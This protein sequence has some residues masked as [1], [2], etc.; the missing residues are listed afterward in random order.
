MRGAVPSLP[1]T[2][3][4]TQQVRHLLVIQDQESRRSISLEAATYSIGR[5]P[6]NSIVLHS[7]RVSRQHAILLRF[8]DPETDNYFFRIVDGNLQGKRSFNGITVNGKACFSHILKHQ[9]LVVF[10][11][12]VKARYHI[13]SNLSNTGFSRYSQAAQ[14]ASLPARSTDTLPFQ[15]IAPSSTELKNL[16]EAA[17]IRLSSFPELIPHPIL[18]IDLLGRITYLNPALLAEFPELPEGN[19]PLLEGLP[20]FAR[21]GQRFQVREVRVGDRIVEQS[22]QCLSESRLIR[23]YLVDITQRKQAEQALRESE[24]RYAAAARGANDGLWDW[25]LRTDIIYFSPRWKSMLGWEETEIG[26][27][28]QEWWQRVHPEDLAQL[29]Q[30]LQNHLQGLRPHFENEHRLRHR[31]GSYRWM[32]SRGLVL[33]EQPQL[34]SRIAGSLMDITEY[35][36][37]QERILHD[38][39][40]DAM[41]GLA[42]RTL[43]MD[44]LNQSIHRS[45]R[46]SQYLFAVLFLD[47]DRFKVINDSLGHLAG[48]QLL[49]GI[50]QRLRS[51]LRQEDTIARFGGDEF[52]ILLEDLQDVHQAVRTAERIQGELSLPFRLA[53]NEVFTS[54]SIGIALSTQPGQTAE[55]L[56]RDADTAMYRAKSLGKAR[57]EIFCPELRGEAIALLQLET[58]LRQALEREEFQAYY[59]PIVDL[60]TGQMSG[61]EALV[62]WQHPE[63]GLLVPGAFWTVAEETGLINGISE[64]ILEQSCRQ[65][66]LWQQQFPI[67]SALTL[68]VNFTGQ[69][70]T[71]ADLLEKLNNT[72]TQTGFLPHCLNLEITESALMKSTETLISLLQKLKVLGIKLHLDDFGTGYSSLSYLH[73]FPIDVLKIDRSFIADLGSNGSTGIVNTILTLAQSLQMEVVAEGIETLEQLTQLK[74]LQCPYGQGYLFAQPMSQQQVESLLAKDSLCLWDKSYTRGDRPP[75]TNPVHPPQFWGSGDNVVG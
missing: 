35:R 65:M 23:S 21:R 46:R 68:S 61:F 50:A 48:D 17:L 34:S 31:D 8:S 3:R 67:S 44:R 62:R 57:H 63:R 22:I 27:H 59:Q 64:W 18:E 60:T 53:N 14:S 29:Q 4:E 11:Q 28:P 36:Q 51:C 72:L 24:E 25:D 15:P 43:M 74:Q 12:D 55:D 49:I 13:I 41:T 56:L 1:V 9:D 37:A 58:E 47:L 19:H 40:H 66:R 45:S 54:A 71:Q 7:P 16:S 39:L 75:A 33:G 52:A 32:R 73:R 30:D 38:A 70:F 5:H 2:K 42:N 26:N 20:E 69:Q 10:G 6:T